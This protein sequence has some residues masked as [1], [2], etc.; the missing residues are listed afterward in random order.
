VK[1]RPNEQETDGQSEDEGVDNQVGDTLYHLETIPPAKTD[2]SGLCQVNSI[3]RKNPYYAT[4][5]MANACQRRPSGRPAAK[6]RMEPN[7]S[8]MSIQLLDQSSDTA[9]S[10][11]EST[12]YFTV[13][14]KPLINGRSRTSVVCQRGPTTNRIG[15]MPFVLF[16]LYLPRYGALGSDHPPQPP[17]SVLLGAPL[18]RLRPHRQTL[19]A[20]RKLCWDRNQGGTVVGNLDLDDDRRGVASVTGFSIGSAFLDTARPFLVL[21]SFFLA[22]VIIAHSSLLVVDAFAMLLLSAISVAF[23]SGDDRVAVQAVL[24]GV[25]LLGTARLQQSRERGAA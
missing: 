17:R 25:L 2:L 12:T 20:S 22:F 19:P 16:W 15:L 1:R 5:S 6:A 10:E 13:Q 3:D 14:S 18:R 11:G 21:A 23:A 8:V 7:I 24:Y 4:A 9:Y